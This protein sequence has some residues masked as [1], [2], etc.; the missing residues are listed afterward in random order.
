MEPQGIS[1]G[2]ILL[3]ETSTAP[4]QTSS[5]RGRAGERYQGMQKKGY[6]R[7]HIQQQR[8]GAHGSILTGK[9]H[10]PP[11]DIASQHAKCNFMA[12]VL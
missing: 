5:H 2:A 3:Y 1:Y 10:K 11:Q 8:G 6:T 4:Y 9:V 12:P 7:R